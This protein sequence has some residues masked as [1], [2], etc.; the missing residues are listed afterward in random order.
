[1][2]VSWSCLFFCVCFLATFLLFCAVFLFRTSGAR[3]QFEYKETKRKRFFCNFLVMYPTAWGKERNRPG[4]LNRTFSVRLPARAVT[5]LGYVK[6][7]HI[8]VRPVNPLKLT[9]KLSLNCATKIELTVIG[10]VLI[11]ISRC[12]TTQAEI[13]CE[14]STNTW[15]YFK[16]KVTC[17]CT[18][19]D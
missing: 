11:Q 13:S 3:S 2:C 8:G 18:N 9:Q 5:A 4:G 16:K 14:I 12:F 1:M 17:D 7:P 6:R 15:N 10:V 19:C